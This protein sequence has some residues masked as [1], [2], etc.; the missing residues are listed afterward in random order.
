MSLQ[1]PISTGIKLDEAELIKRCKQIRFVLTDIDGVWT[2]ARFYYSAEGEM[3]KAFSTYDGMA[4]E[5]LRNAGL[6]T[7]VISGE[8]S[9]AV[10]KRVE[11][12]NIE[13]V[14]LGIRNKLEVIEAFL[15]EQKATFDQV[16]YVGDD[17]NDLHMLRAA[18]LTAVPPNSPALHFLPHDI[19][20]DRSGGQGAFR[21]FA[22]IILF[23][24]RLD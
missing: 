13:H 1:K 18:G 6:S 10:R 11:K 17:V 7:V 5:L 12:L 9:P 3:L 14:F 20:L 8:N 19:L 16:A 4:V 15:Q 22:D 24:R 2:D 23:Y 21:Q